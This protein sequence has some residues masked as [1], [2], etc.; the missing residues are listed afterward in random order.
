MFAQ[1]LVNSSCYALD[2]F[3]VVYSLLNYA[4]VL[5]HVPAVVW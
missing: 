3:T 2:L 5:I 4:R 1:V